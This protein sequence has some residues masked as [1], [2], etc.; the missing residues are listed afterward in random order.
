MAI[1]IR[2]KMIL[3]IGLPAMTIFMAVLF[4]LLGFAEQQ[5]RLMHQA[6]MAEEA[7]A[8]AEQFDEYIGKAAQVA[9]ITARFIKLVPD[10]QDEEIYGILK[11]NVGL[12][13]RIYGAAMAFEP[14]TYKE[15]NRLFSPYVYED[16]AG[17][18]LV[19]M[20]INEQVYDW[21][22]DEQWQW[23]HLPKQRQ[24]GV[25]TDP[26][27]D[28][29]A[30]NILMVTY[31]VPFQRNGAFGGVTT[32]DID[33]ERLGED[34]NKAIPG[35]GDFVILGP[36]GRFIYSK[37]K[38]M[39]LAHSIFDVLDARKNPSS[40]EAMVR[41]LLEGGSGEVTVEDLL[42]QGPVIHA[43]APIPSTGWTFVALHPEKTVMAEFR[44]RRAMVIGGFAGA[45][46]LMLMTL[47]FMSGKVAGPI[48][49]LREQVLRVAEGDGEFQVSDFTSRDEIGELA[50]AFADLQ[51]KV[52]DREVR[53]ETAR[54]RTLSEL[55]ESA[56]DAMAVVDREG[57]ICR[58]NEKMEEMFGFSRMQV[59]GDSILRLLPE[60]EASEGPGRLSTLLRDP[61]QIGG[62]TTMGLQ[63][64]RKGGDA[65]PVE[66]GMA[67][68]HEPE[69]LMSVI[70]IRDMTQREEARRQVEAAA[71][72]KSEFLAHMSHE[73]RTPLN[74]IIGFSQ[75]LGRDD[76]LD[77]DTRRTVRTIERSGNHLLTL[78][79]DILEMS[80]IEA[81]QLTMNKES[82]SLRGIAEDMREMMGLKARQKGLQFELEWD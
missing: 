81:G 49:K 33:L 3:F 9:D 58:I 43:Y 10:L 54:E 25:W 24:E 82:V 23:W 51:E 30:G 52:R 57:R 5:A 16:K 78:I 1:S 12:N 38:E 61:A 62:A 59:T 44:K 28:E 63:G 22:R 41:R 67:P 45:G 79:N 31:A 40:A 42:D 39:I 21:Y 71:H 29:G 64:M 18:G 76:T 47:F 32:V 2:A 80:K 7:A 60:G 37:D 53:L 66:I 20:D 68:F 56:P 75:L 50:K 34:V 65:F 8:V 36:D 70:V 46:V 19:E 72:A 48:R 14:G 55:L 27:F 74:A 4:W 73:I 15:G 6:E 13:R 17:G 11:G 69:G 26:Y 77:D 35:V